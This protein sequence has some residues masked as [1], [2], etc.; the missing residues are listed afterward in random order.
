M[1]QSDSWAPAF[2]HGTNAQADM[3]TA[4]WRRGSKVSRGSAARR[5]QDYCDLAH[6]SKLQGGGCME[7]FCVCLFALL[8]AVT[9]CHSLLARAG[10][11]VLAAC[12]GSLDLG[13]T[14]SPASIETLHSQQTAQGGFCRRQA[15]EQQHTAPT[16]FKRSMLLLLHKIQQRPGM[17]AHCWTCARSAQCP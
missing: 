2:L 8:D 5:I 6:G 12:E 7:L 13:V 3:E 17:A 14:P 11:R 9:L 15:G 4:C 1:Y 16:S 10:L